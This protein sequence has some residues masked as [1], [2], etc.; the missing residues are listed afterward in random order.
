[1]K[2][3]P[4]GC[5]TMMKDEEGFIYPVSSEHCIHCKK[6]EAVCPIL[7]QPKSQIQDKIVYAGK[8]KKH[9]VWK[10]SS[11]GGAFYEICNSWG[12]SDTLY[13]G[14]V[15]D[16]LTVKH[17]CV[18]GIEN[19]GP[20]QKS[21]YIYSDTNGSFSKIKNYLDQGRYV[22]FSGTPCQVA[23][24]KN[25]LNRDYERL[26][27]IDLVCHGVG[28]PDV[29]HNCISLLEKR[30]S[31]IIEKIEFRSKKECYDFDHLSLITING[32]GIYIINDPYTQLFL[33][34]A[35]LRPSCGL[36]C[37]FRNINRQGDITIA[38]FKG[39]VDV[40]PSLRGYKENYSTIIINTKKA[41]TIL[42]SLDSKMNLLKCEIEDIE[43][44]NPLISGQSQFAVENQN[45]EPFFK[46]YISDHEVAIE[47][48][49]SSEVEEYNP[50]IKRRIWNLLPFFIRHQIGR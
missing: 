39:L 17:D 27:T 34:Q 43:K 26:L 18:E 31:G 42:E 1:M 3:C 30:Y 44:Y 13:F 50:S 24:L 19:I 5:I 9:S 37:Q 33:S 21:K 35:C 6:C 12:E 40:F 25:Y 23:G 47:E 49:M 2:A 45:R 15:W 41:F 16:G 14:A 32:K 28:S 4:V 11:S 48:F 38:D 46:K 20:L 36:N 7:N 22:V 8:S 29:F 10:A